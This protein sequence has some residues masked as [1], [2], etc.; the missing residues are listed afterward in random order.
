MKKLGD[1]WGGKEEDRTG[2]S[3]PSLLEGGEGGEQFGPRSAGAAY[4][5]IRG[6]DKPGFVRPG[7]VELPRRYCIGLNR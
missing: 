4:A 6:L 2:V 1:S 5:R 7:G 3:T